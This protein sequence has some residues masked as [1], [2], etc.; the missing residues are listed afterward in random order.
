MANQIRVT[1]T[2]KEE[3]LYKY[4]KDKTSASAFLKDLAKREMLRDENY[5]N[6]NCIKNQE[7][8]ITDEIQEKEDLNLTDVDL[9]FE[10]DDL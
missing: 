3:K 9:D 2:D 6:F 8:Y 5:I 1:F 10:I 7:I 4:I